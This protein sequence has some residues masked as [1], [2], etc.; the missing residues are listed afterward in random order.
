MSTVLAGSLSLLLASGDVHVHVV[1]ATKDSLFFR[2][3]NVASLP[4]REHTYSIIVSACFWDCYRLVYTC[5][6]SEIH[7]TYVFLIIWTRAVVFYSINCRIHCTLCLICN[8]KY[9]WVVCSPR[10]INSK[11]SREMF[12][13]SYRGNIDDITFQVSPSNKCLKN[14][15]MVVVNG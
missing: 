7:K 5:I 12:Y 6:I 3:S 8:G 13:M 14:N 9:R 1:Q 11:I 4:S 10:V 15:K 2:H